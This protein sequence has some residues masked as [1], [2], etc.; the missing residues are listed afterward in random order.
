MVFDGLM[1][2]IIQTHWN[3]MTMRRATSGQ[4]PNSSNVLQAD[5]ARRLAAYAASTLRLVKPRHSYK[6][7][8]KS[9]R[10]QGIYHP[11]SKGGWRG[12]PRDKGF[13]GKVMRKKN[14]ELIVQHAM[15]DCRRLRGK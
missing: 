11:I 3:S 8:R 2:H 15:F 13:E 5:A 6:P 14:G 4:M 9:P 10:N 7:M 12:N 1:T